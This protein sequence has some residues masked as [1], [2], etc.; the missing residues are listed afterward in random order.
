[1]NATKKMLVACVMIGS[2]AL[3]AGQANADLVLNGQTIQPGFNPTGTGGAVTLQNNTVT[4]TFLSSGTLGLTGAVTGAHVLVVAG[5]G[6]GGGQFGGGGGAGGLIYYGPETPTNGHRQGTSLDIA[7][8]DTTVTVGGGG[9]G[10]STGGSSGGTG[11]SNGGNSAFGGVIATGGG[12]GG[13][14]ADSYKN[15]Q[16]GG[17]GGGAGHLGAVG[18]GTLGQGFAG[19]FGL[20]GQG[21][22]GGGGAGAIGGNSVSGGNGL[23]YSI[24]GTGTYYYA[25]GGGG[26]FASGGGL[27]GGGTAP[28]GSAPT[29]GAANTGGGGGGASSIYGSGTY[30]AGAAGG[31]GIVIISYARYLNKTLS[32]VI[33]AKSTSTLDALGNGGLI[34]VASGM[35]GAGGINIDSSGAPGGV[36]DYQVAQSYLGAT[37]VRAG[38][39]LMVTPAGTSL[40]GGLYLD[41]IGIEG[42]DFGK[43]DLVSGITTVPFAYTGGTGGTGYSALAPGDYTSANLPDYITGAGTLHVVPEPATMAFLALGGLAMIGS[44]IRRRRTA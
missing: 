20:A 43:L 37:T 16:A 23:P 14:A 22:G 31:S 41:Y 28:Y 8:G 19:G 40:T 18:S 30:Y 2:L 34:T 26:V 42:F 29:V 32:G 21:Y 24:S 35:T 44:A 1:M 3:F 33:T 10:G 13:G 25:G 39:T 38:A 9:A 17:S 4:H 7:S 11:G 15:G 5:G 36:V 27:G 12:G 6:G